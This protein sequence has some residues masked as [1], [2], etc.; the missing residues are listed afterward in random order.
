MSDYEFVAGFEDVRADKRSMPRHFIS[1]MST[2][3]AV[4]GNGLCR[5]MGGGICADPPALPL[6]QQELDSVYE[7]PFL[8]ECHP[9]FDY[10]PAIEE[11]RFS[12]VSSR[13][14]YG[15]CAFCA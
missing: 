4:A 15:G 9:A 8:K 11:V 6:S 14:C 13:G 10:V 3:Y 1:S 5:P 7:L 2:R 12:L